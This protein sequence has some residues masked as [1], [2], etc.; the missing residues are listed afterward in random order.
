MR[1]RL[2]I[3]IGLATSIVALVMASPAHASTA[4]DDQYAGVLGE[5]GGGGPAGQAAGGLPFTGLD[6]VLVLGA[7]TGL[8]ATGAGLRRVARERS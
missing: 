8:A 5:Q 6:L 1:T 7:G 3:V 2:R 4:A